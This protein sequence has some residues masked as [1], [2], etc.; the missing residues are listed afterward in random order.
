MKTIWKF[1][2]ELTDAQQVAIPSGAQ[3]LTAQIQ[4]QSLQLWALVD[5]AQPKHVHTIRIIGTG[6]PIEEDLGK[7]VATFQLRDGELI[8][9]VFDAL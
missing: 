8:F 6:H 3:L 5:P 2:L 1:P 9:H 4:G 7:Y